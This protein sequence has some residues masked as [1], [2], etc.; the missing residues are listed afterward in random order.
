MQEQQH[1]YIELLRAQ[2]EVES[3]LMVQTELVIALRLEGL[4][5]SDERAELAR[6]RAQADKIKEQLDAK[7]A[8]LVAECRRRRPLPQ[9]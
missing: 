8:S 2:I 9:E 7:L 4:A 1:T 5:A 6:L 3:R